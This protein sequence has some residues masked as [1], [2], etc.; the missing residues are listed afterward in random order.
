[1]QFLID[2]G[3]VLFRRESIRLSSD[4]PNTLTMVAVLPHVRVL[5]MA[6]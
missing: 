2:R 3:C 4:S 1:M 5:D 6:A